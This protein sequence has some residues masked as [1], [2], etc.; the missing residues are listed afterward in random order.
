MAGKVLVDADACPVRREIVELAGGYRIVMVCGPGQDFPPVKGVELV[1]VDSDRE[2]ADLAIA[3]RAQP[4]DLVLC[5]DLGLACLAI[6]RGAR[7]LTFRGRI[8]DSANIDQALGLRHAHARARRGGGRHKGPRAY[9]AEDRQRFVAEL[10]K[11][12]AQA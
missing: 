4:G 12:L 1:R 2:A 10:G 8:Y 9:T 11:L 5:E 3:N 7:V 6:A